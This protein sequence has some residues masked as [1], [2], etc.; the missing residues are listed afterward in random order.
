MQYLIGYKLFENEEKVSTEEIVKKA[1]KYKSMLE[2][3]RRDTKLY[4]LIRNNNLEYSVFPK[5]SK[6]T[7]EEI[8]K[9]SEKYNT[10]GEF[11]QKS[12]GAYARALGL[13]ML[14][15]LFPKDK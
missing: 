10:R 4:W 8:E 13:N 2:L 11:S 9:E 3:R 7:K 14:D 1:S 5:K 12:H 15:E 6:W